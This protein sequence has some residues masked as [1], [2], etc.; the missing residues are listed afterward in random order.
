[1]VVG[2]IFFSHS[3][4]CSVTQSFKKISEAVYAEIITAD[5]IPVPGEQCRVTAAVSGS[6][7]VSFKLETTF[8]MKRT[9]AQNKNKGIGSL[10]KTKD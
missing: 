10:A 6:F 5:T 1:M 2:G 3:V 8:L 7:A 9:K 4:N